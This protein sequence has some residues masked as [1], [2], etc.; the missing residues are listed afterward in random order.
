MDPEELR[1]SSL[2]RWR[3]PGVALDGAEAGRSAAP[4]VPPRSRRSGLRDGRLGRGLDDLRVRRRRRGE[5]LK[6]WRRRR[7]SGQ[8]PSARRSLPDGADAEGVVQLHLEHR[9]VRR[10]LSRFLSQGF[11][12]GLSRVCVIAGPGAQPRVVLL[13]RLA[14][15]GPG[16]RGCT[17]RSSPSPRPGRGGRGT[18]PLQALRRR[19]ARRPRWPSSRRRCATRAARPPTRSS[20]S[21]PGRQGCGRP[22]TRARRRAEAAKADARS[23]AERGESEATSLGDLLAGSARPHRRRRGRDQTTR[24]SPCSAP[25]RRE[26]RRRDRRHWRGASSNGLDRRNRDRAR[27]ACGTATASRADRLEPVGARLSLAGDRLSACPRRSR[28]E[29][30][31]AWPRPADRPRRRRLRPGRARPRAERSRPRADSDAVARAPQLTDRTGPALRR[32]LGVLR[33]DPRLA[34]RVRSPARPA[35]PTL[36]DELS[37]RSA[38]VRHRAWRPPGPLPRPDGEAGRCWSASRRPASIRTRAARSTAGRRR[39]TSGS[40]A[41]CARPAC[42]PACC[43]TDGRAAAG[44][45]PE[46]GETQRLARVPA[47]RARRRSAAGRCWAA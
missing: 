11:Q 16:A 35:A 9:L 22:R 5:T 30:R 26:Q 33:R 40:S 31:M 13:G 14:L 42:P 21:A 19:A 3:A 47:A 2:R 1:P 24:S 45:C 7:R 18:T 17:R 25:T 15:Y 10:L 41:C 36:P 46:G 43:V 37:C 28:P 29:P 6:E 23:L 32:P 44:L 38:G 27:R 4:L 8:S 39:R 20:A 34:A 12:S